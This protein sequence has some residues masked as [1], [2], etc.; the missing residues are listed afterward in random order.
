MKVEL[1]GFGQYAD[2]LHM[3]TLE[4]FTWRDIA[5]VLNI[6]GVGYYYVQADTISLRYNS[7]VDP[8]DVAAQ[9][10]RVL[11]EACRIAPEEIVVTVRDS[12]VGDAK[13][14]MLADEVWQRT[15]VAVTPPMVSAT[16]IVPRGT[17]PAYWLRN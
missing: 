15:C 17:G 6:P 1:S 14:L 16:Q 8:R 9:A 10:L 5:P 4:H 2:T 13:A 11:A 3:V 7:L 12:F